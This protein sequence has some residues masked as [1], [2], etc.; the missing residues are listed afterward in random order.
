[1]RQDWQTLYAANRSAIREA[2]L[3]DPGVAPAPRP[4]TPRAAAAG[5][6]GPLAISRAVTG[7]RRVS[8][9]PLVCMLHGCT[10]DAASFAAATRMNELA[11]RQGFVVV[12][13]QQQR[14]ANQQACWNW[15]DPSHQARGRG[16]PAAIATIVSELAADESG[17]RS[18]SGASSSPACRRAARWRRSSARP[19]PTCSPPSR[20]TRG[21]PTAPRTTCA[22]PSRRCARRGSERHR[23]G[24]AHSG[25]AAGAQPRDPRQRGPDG[26]ADQRR[27][28]ARQAMSANRLAAPALAP[29]RRSDARSTTRPRGRTPTPSRAGTTRAASSARGADRRGAGARLV[30][31]R[32]RGVVHAIRA[33]R[34]RRRRS[35]ASSTA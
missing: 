28:A 8:R 33:G 27:A 16:E 31:R 29:D 24:G 5:H 13:P 3:P 14:R 4:A 11:D 23:R 12:Y 21:C 22:A 25:R 19:I 34:T 30:R 32:A 15:F 2:G 26:R 20:C 6:D 17:P 9:V 10:Q 18:T 1:M 35:G 7:R